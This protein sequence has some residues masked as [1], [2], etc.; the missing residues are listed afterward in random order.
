MYVIGDNITWKKLKK[1]MVVLNLSNNEFHTLNEADSV[2]WDCLI[3]KMTIK[4]TMASLMDQ[5]DATQEECSEW[6][7]KGIRK[8]L[9][10]V[11]IKEN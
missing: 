11:L 2:I 7:E 1:G 8:L 6:V 10:D 9:E 5:F 4:D 3:K